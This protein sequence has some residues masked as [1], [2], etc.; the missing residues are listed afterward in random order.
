MNRFASVSLLLAG[1]VGLAGIVATSQPAAADAAKKPG[2]KAVERTRKVVKV[3]DEVYKRSIILI[4]DKYVDN[5][6]DF[7]AG[8]AF[9]ELFTQISE[10]GTHSVRL[11]DLTGEPYD[12]DNVAQD[13]FEKAGAKK[14]KAGEAYYDQ[15]VREDGEYR[16][17]VITA[18]P[19]VMEKCVMCHAHYADVPEG[20]AIG[21]ITYSIPID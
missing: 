5:E 21:A 13:A 9:V 7:P 17:R 16:L 4:T 15:V 3:L 14:I 12:S 11:I 8:S 19:V 20:E 18:V 1:V 6:D 2:R 10:G